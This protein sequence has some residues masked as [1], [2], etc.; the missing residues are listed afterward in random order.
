MKSL[1]NLLINFLFLLFTYFI[2]T[3]TCFSAI[4]LTINSSG[5]EQNK[6]LLQGF[7]S[8]NTELNETINIIKNTIT[9]NLNTTNLVQIIEN[10]TFLSTN[11]SP[12]NINTE[13][14]PDFSQSKRLGIDNL[15]VANFNYNARGDLELKIRM[16]DVQDQRQLFGKFYTASYDNFR[17]LSHSI[18]NEI[19]KAITQEAIG[20]FSSK[21]VY[22]SEV[23]QVLKRIKRL[24][25]IDFDGE[26]HRLLT[27]GKE[28]VLTP[29]FSKDKQEIF[30]LRY[31]EKKPQIFSLNLRNMHSQKIGGFK[32][33]TFASSPHPKDS[34]LILL[35]AIIDGNCDIFELNISGNFAKR[36]T[37]SPAIDT[38]ASY[39]ADGKQIVF[40]SDR[41]NNQQLYVM[42]NDGTQINRISYGGGSY[43]K[44][45][46]SSDNKLIAFT[47]IKGGQF[48]IGIMNANGKNEKILTTGYLV[49]GAKWSP[50]G[51]YLIYSKKTGPY[52]LNSI[53]RLFTID[54]VTGYEYEIP[55]PKLEGASDP[56]WILE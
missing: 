52:G 56:D 33:T 50:N 3:K 38:T 27:D 55:T 44:P 40:A 1:K 21:I 46:W 31:F 22:V 14:I 5:L 16:W 13:S 34:N 35:S 12:E 9:K 24:A 11:N 39:S 15:L 36:L 43:S 4:T 20:H 32:A 25:T 29:T 53:P 49:E 48:M 19:F 18:A 37:K 8:S 17:K 6:I 23:G 41:E 26:N 47:K 2:V 7:S 42:N 28:L 30:Y 10:Q 51:R 45:S 54:I